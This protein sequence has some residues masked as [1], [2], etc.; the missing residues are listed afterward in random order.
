M[1]FVFWLLFITSYIKNCIFETT[2]KKVRHRPLYI[3]LLVFK[4]LIR[5]R[6]RP[7]LSP[8]D[9]PSPSSPFG[10]P[11]ANIFS[12]AFPSLLYRPRLS[13]NSF[14]PQPRSP[15]RSLFPCSPFCLLSPSPFDRRGLCFHSLGSV[16]CQLSIIFPY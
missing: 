5:K 4:Q 16:G 9:P 10:S 12:S 7:L 11:A 6:H 2:Y 1:D 8:S 14:A 15:V 13:I 3:K